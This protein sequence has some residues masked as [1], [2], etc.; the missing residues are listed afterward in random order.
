MVLIYGAVY[1][2]KRDIARKIYG[3]EDFCNGAS[4][5]FDA[6]LCARAVTNFHSLVR[7]LLQA[8]RSAVEYTER[9]TEQNPDV[10]VLTDD[11]G[12]GIVPIEREERLWREACGICMR[13]LAERAD[14]VIRVV[15]GIPQV[16]KGELP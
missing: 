4:A 8:D 3:V 15:C 1:A 5:P 12:S 10:I 9:L 11:I 6:L 7:R 13:L 14:T 2:G 16:L